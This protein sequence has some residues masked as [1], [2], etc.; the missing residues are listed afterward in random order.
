MT[1]D[2]AVQFCHWYPQKP[3]PSILL[4]QAKI[5]PRHS[6]LLNLLLFGIVGNIMKP[7]R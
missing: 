2:Y 4:Q 7:G 3:L 1:N 5:L 6:T